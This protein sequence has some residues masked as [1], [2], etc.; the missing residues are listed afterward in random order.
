MSFELGFILELHV[1]LELINLVGAILAHLS[2]RSTQGSSFI[3]VYVC[4]NHTTRFTF[5]HKIN[6][7][8]LLVRYRCLRVLDYSLL[9]TRFHLFWLLN[10]GLCLYL[11]VFNLRLLF[12]TI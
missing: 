4:K 9:R 11:R 6:H 3:S 2:R 12:C 7:V 5:R 1:L 10:S 8:I